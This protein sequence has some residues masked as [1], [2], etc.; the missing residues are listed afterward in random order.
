M[1]L[2]NHKAPNG[3]FG[4][5]FLNPHQEPYGL[6]VAINGFAGMVLVVKRLNQRPHIARNK[7]LLIIR[8]IQVTNLLIV[9]FVYFFQ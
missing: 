9:R 6:V 3:H 2:I 7:R 1:A 4:W 8:H 5:R